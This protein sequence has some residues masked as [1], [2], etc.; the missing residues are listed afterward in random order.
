MR[1]K[2][3]HKKAILCGSLLKVFCKG[4]AHESRR[5]PVLNLKTFT[6]ELIAIKD[7]NFMDK[8]LI[9]TV[10]KTKDEDTKDVY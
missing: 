4:T 6:E 10:T 2:M 9:K 3:R 7:N 1:N 8:I 5:I